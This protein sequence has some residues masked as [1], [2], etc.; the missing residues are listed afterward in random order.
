MRF[1]FSNL[2]TRLLVLYYQPQ[3]QRDSSSDGQIRQQK[4]HGIKQQEDMRNVEVK[5]DKKMKKK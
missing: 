2:C 1:D 4:I 5:Q 3:I